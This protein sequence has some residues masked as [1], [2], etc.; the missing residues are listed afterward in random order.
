MFGMMPNKKGKHGSVPPR[1]SE[2]LGMNTAAY[3]PTRPV[4]YEIEQRDGKPVAVAVKPNKQ[5]CFKF[6]AGGPPV[7]RH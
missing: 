6:Q 5:A 2:C 4:C 7:Y 1:C 3:G